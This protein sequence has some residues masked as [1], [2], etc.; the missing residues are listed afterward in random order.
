LGI[1]F[2]NGRGTPADE[3]LA[4]HWLRRAAEENDPMCLFTI[5]TIYLDGVGVPTDTQFAISLLKRSA[6]G[7]LPKAHLVLGLLYLE[8][9]GVSKNNHEA[10]RFF[11]QAFLL[12]EDSARLPQETAAADLKKSEL[13]TLEKLAEGNVLQLLDQPGIAMETP[14]F[15]DNLIKWHQYFR[16]Y[17]WPIGIALF[18]WEIIA[19]RL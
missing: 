15:G 6:E 18:L 5:G 11:H 3:I 19:Q 2:K 17:I 4:S 12:G 13:E 1:L 14:E 7:G 8:G 9:R 16:T 10:Y